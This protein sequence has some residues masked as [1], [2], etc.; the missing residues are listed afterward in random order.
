MNFLPGVAT[1]VT[2][3]RVR[4]KTVKGGRRIASMKFGLQLDAIN[5]VHMPAFIASAWRSMS[6]GAVWRAELDRIVESQTIYFLQF[7]E[8]GEVRLELQGVD[9]TDVRLVKTEDKK[10]WL[11]FT[12]VQEIGAGL[13]KWIGL[14]F[15]KQIAARF[16]ECQQELPLTEAPAKSKAARSVH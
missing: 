12:V 3:D 2:F 7:L 9:L 11:F 16:E 4:A 10:I 14:N 13:W 8:D 1:W 6:D 15:A 5:T